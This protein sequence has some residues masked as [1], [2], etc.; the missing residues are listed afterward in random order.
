MRALRL[1]KPKT[2]FRSGYAYDN[3]LYVVARHLIELMFT[4]VD[5]V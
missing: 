5:K 1:L 2:S 3:V 4:P